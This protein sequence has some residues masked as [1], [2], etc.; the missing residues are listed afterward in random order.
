[1]HVRF[2]IA[3]GLLASIL[4]VVLGQHVRDLS[5]EHWSLSSRALNRTVPAQFPSQVHL[6]LL[7]AGMIGE[8]LRASIPPKLRL[9]NNRNRRS[10]SELVYR[11]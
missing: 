11:Q 8:C 9:P 10:V 4:P 2:E 5:S 3:T 1:M 6:D 7:K